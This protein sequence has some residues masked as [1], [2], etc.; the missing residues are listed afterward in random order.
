MDGTLSG[1]AGKA[2]P[3]GGVANFNLVGGGSP[4][5]SYLV[6]NLAFSKGICYMNYDIITFSLHIKKKI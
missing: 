3:L 4:W 6:G 5:S 1:E 2:T